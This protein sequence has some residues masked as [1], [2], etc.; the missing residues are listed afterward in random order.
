MSDVP[1]QIIEKCGWCGVKTALIERARHLAR[2]YEM[3]GWG[4]IET[5]TWVLYECVSCSRP[6]LRAEWYHEGMEEY[7]F[8]WLLPTGQRDDSN[9]PSPV[10]KAWEAA[11]AVRHVEP[12]AFAVLVGRTLEVIS[13]EEAAIGTNLVAKLRW[14]ADSGRIPGPLAEMAQKLRRIRNLGAH[15]STDE[16]REGDVPVI[17]EFADAILEYLYRA[18]AKLAA[19]EARLD[20]PPPPPMAS[21]S[22]ELSSEPNEHA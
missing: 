14:L 4:V 20:V 6:I 18:P 7:A 1:D 21:V 3:E 11:L 9:L 10:A 12:N 5:Q 19:V 16:I 17:Y 22:A 15:A 13:N 8:E 2:P